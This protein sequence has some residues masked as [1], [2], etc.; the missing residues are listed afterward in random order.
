MWK[1][2]D[3]EDVLFE[4]VVI[5]AMCSNDRTGRRRRDEERGSSE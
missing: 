4:P 5:D 2:A 1:R 3:F